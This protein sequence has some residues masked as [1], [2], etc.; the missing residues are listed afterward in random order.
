CRDRADRGRQSEATAGDPKLKF[1]A[2]EV[3]RQSSSIGPFASIRQVFAPDRANLRV[4]YGRP[5]E[6]DDEQTDGQKA[7]RSGYRLLRAQTGAMG[8]KAAEEGP[9]AT[10][11]ER[12]ET[13]SLAYLQQAAHLHHRVV[14]GC[15]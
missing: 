5:L 13:S 9:Q 14:C 12:K 15:A 1:V 6:H 11:H 7:R 8:E 10:R 2:Q 3:R 4:D